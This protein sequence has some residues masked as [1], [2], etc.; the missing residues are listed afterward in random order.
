MLAQEQ[1]RHFKTFG[2]VNMREV[3][4]KDELDMINREIEE[5]MV[6]AYADDP[7]DGTQRHWVPMFNQTTPFLANLL[8]DPRLCEVAEQLYGDDTIGMLADANRYVGNTNW[9]PDT[10][11][12]HQ[13]GVK[14]AFY[15]DPV[16]PD[17][18]ALRVIP[19]SHQLPLHEELDGKVGARELA[20]DELPGFVCASEPG[21]VVAFDLRL[22]HGSRGGSDDRRMCTCVYYNNPKTPEE[23]EATYDQAVNSSKS[24]ASFHA[25]GITVYNAHWLSNPNASARRA[26]WIKRLRE[27]DFIQT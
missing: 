22:W 23:E 9:H 13:Y 4:T 7:F 19:G 21:D 2:F 3:F 6:A 14:F 27:L 1:V 12:I 11:S 20:V 24:S 8:E 25:H 26:R 10:G 16:G 15:L 17:S 18:G 5:R